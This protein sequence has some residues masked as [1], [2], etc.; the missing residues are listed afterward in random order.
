MVAIIRSSFALVAPQT[1][2]LGRH[3]Y[4]TLFSAAPETRDLFP[5]NMEVQRSRLLRALVHVVQMVDQRDE[6][7]P[8]LQQL[9]RDH[10][11]FGVLA[12]HYDAVGIALIG[13]IEHF[14]GDAFTPDGQ[15]RVDRGVRHRRAG[16]AHRGGRR[17]GARLVAGPG[18]QPR[19][20]GLGPGPDHRAGQ[21]SHPVPGGPVRERRD[22]AAAAAVALPLARQRAA[23]RRLAGVPRAGGEQRLGQ[24]RDRRALPRRRHLADRAADG[25]A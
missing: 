19:A 22:A 5:V 17:A 10:R 23:A 7:V 4:A 21:R 6:L 12:E 8:F 11:K 24:P 3:F 15:G 25:P 9:G 2:A 20:R 1:D 18:G 13:A 14:S 16:D